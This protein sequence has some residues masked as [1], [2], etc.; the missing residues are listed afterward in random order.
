MSTQTEPVALR[1]CCTVQ[2]TMQ[3][4]R[5]QHDNISSTLFAELPLQHTSM[6]LRI[7]LDQT[8]SRIAGGDTG[9]FHPSGDIGA[10]HATVPLHSTYSSSITAAK[11]T[12]VL[13]SKLSAYASRTN[14]TAVTLCH[15]STLYHI[16][17]IY[18]YLRW[19]GTTEYQVLTNKYRPITSF[20]DTKRQNNL[21]MYVR[22]YEYSTY[23]STIQLPVTFHTIVYTG[24]YDTKQSLSYAYT[25]NLSRPRRTC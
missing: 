15:A 1:Y 19:I 17:S 25:N 24:T 23:S 8:T 21:S 9:C 12:A 3:Y 7:Q 6:I 5:H 4:N 10:R 22:V 18:N 2:Y 16:M 14:I 11:V 20:L 13:P